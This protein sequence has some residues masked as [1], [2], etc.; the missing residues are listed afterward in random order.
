MEAKFKIDDAVKFTNTIENKYTIGDEGRIDVDGIFERN[1]KFFYNVKSAGKLVSD[2]PEDDIDFVYSSVERNV[3]EVLRR[4]EE[5]RSFKDSDVRVG[6]TKKEKM[7]YKGL[8]NFEDLKNIEKDKVIAK[9]L[10]NK[11]KVYPEINTNEQIDKGV[12]GGTL[13]LKMKLREFVHKTPPDTEQFRALYVGLCQ[14]LYELFDDAVTIKDF[15]ERRNL[16]INGVIRK[17]I[18]ISNPELEPELI[19][20]NKEYEQ[21]VERLTEYEENF[22]KASEKLYELANKADIPTWQ[23]QKLQEAFPEAF[24]ETEYW[25]KLR[26]I[27]QNFKGNKVLPLEFRFL[28]NLAVINEKGKTVSVLTSKELPQ[29]DFGESKQIDDEY[30]IRY[31]NSV[32]YELIKSVLGDRFQYFIRKIESTKAIKDVWE[33]YKKYEPFTQEQYD[34]VYEKDIKYYEEKANEYKTHINFLSDPEKS[35]RE[36]VDYGLANGMGSWYWTNRKNRTFSVMVKR[37]DI[38]DAIRLMNSIVNDPKSGYQSKID[39]YLEKVSELKDKYFVRENNYAFL[40]KEKKERKKGERSELVINSGVPLSH[41]IR[42]GCIEVKDSDLNTNDKVLSYY[43]NILGIKRLTYGSTLP[44][45]ERIIHAKRFA[46]SIIDI[47]EALNWDIKSLTGLGDLGIMFAASGSGRA[48]AHFSPDT[49]AINLTRSKGDGSLSHELGHYLDFNIALKYPNDRR[50]EKNHA[51]YGSYIHSG[52]RNISDNKIMAAMVSL[53]DFIVNGVYVNNRNEFDDTK[54]SKEHPVVQKILPL[55]PEFVESV[56]SSFVTIKV[57]KNNRTLKFQKFEKIEEYI[58]YIKN[59]YPQYLNYNY[60]LENKTTVLDTLGAVLNE[61]KTDSY[62][63]QL[64]NK[65]YSRG[66]LFNRSKSA[67]YYKNKAMKSPYWVY[68]WELFA[69]SFETFVFDKMAESG[70]SNNY[71]VSGAYFNRPEG[72]YPFGI[73]RKIFYIL[74]DHLFNTIKE[75]MSIPDFKMEGN[76][77]DEYVELSDNDNNNVEEENSL[78]IDEQTKEVI[79]GDNELMKQ[80][81]IAIQK[82]IKLKELLSKSTHKFND[83]GQINVNENNLIESLFSFSK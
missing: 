13:F 7:A 80:K 26:Q 76:R 68:F 2:V 78:I 39:E 60:Y 82:M 15:E 65:P 56:M 50:S 9:K 43:K 31:S 27:A 8:I 41:I 46:Q 18:L 22:D 53:M 28:H 33:D 35:Y 37:G 40:E 30:V 75:E 57:E 63:F 71:L 12:T 72:V 77:V 45:T 6:G 47:S 10:V 81:E 23:D 66:S 74:H 21:E 11:D 29:G 69:R 59:H 20:Q 4:K 42:N 1:G 14:W 24:K 62:E 58:E 70:R 49:N 83:G 34:A 54:I 17:S 67:F 55:M 16:F 79:D 52:A 38:D 5:K 25:K 73:E 64:F 61:L 51:V 36:K 3:D 32:R 44:D 48:S 19:L